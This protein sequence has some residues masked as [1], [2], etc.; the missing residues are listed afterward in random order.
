MTDYTALKSAA[1][2]AIEAA[3]P[4][5][6]TGAWLVAIGGFQDLASPTAILALIERVELMEGLLM[7]A[8]EQLPDDGTR[9]DILGWDLTA[10]INTALSGEGK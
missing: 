7:E 5:H 10:R 1:K 3:K 9:R 2:A 4:G 8:M 6:T